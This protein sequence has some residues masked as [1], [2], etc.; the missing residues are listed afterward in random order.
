MSEEYL[1]YVIKKYKIDYVIHGDD[2]C[3]VNGKDV[4]ESAKKAGKFQSI[5]RTEGVSTTDIVGRMLLMNKDHHYNSIQ[6]SEAAE[7]HDGN[8]LLCEQSQ[9]LT[10]S[11]MLRLF[12]AGM[13]SSKPGQ[14]I[15]YVD[16]AFDMFHCGHVTFLQQAKKV[17]DAIKFYHNF[18]NIASE[19]LSHILLFI[20]E[21]II[22]LLG[23]IVISL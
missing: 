15:L 6:E 16:G 10:T 14:K 3:I 4:Y 19:Q 23:S 11:R 22:S 12:S 5:P 13:K 8:S 9:F 17:R 1:E 7:K 21:E 2:P 20:R 18:C